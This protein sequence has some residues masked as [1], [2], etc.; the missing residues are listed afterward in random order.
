MRWIASEQTG[1]WVLRLTEDET[2]TSCGLFAGS[3]HGQGE[4]L[5]TDAERKLVGGALWTCAFTMHRFGISVYRKEVLEQEVEKI[6]GVLD[7]LSSFEY[8]EMGSLFQIVSTER[9]WPYLCIHP[10]LSTSSR[11]GT[12]WDEQTVRNTLLLHA[13]FERELLTLATPTF[14]LQHWPLSHFLTYRKIRKMRREKREKWRA[15]GKGKK[16]EGRWQRVVK[17]WLEEMEWEDEVEQE[18]ESIFGTER[19]CWEDGFGQVER[20]VV[21][22]IGAF[23]GGLL[24]GVL[25]R[26]GE[27]AGDEESSRQDANT[28]QYASPTPTPPLPS[29]HSSPSSP[30]DLSPPYCPFP[31]VSAL[32]FPIPRLGTTLAPAPL[33]A[34][35]DLLTKLFLF[36]HQYTEDVVR[37]HIL[38]VREMSGEEDERAVDTLSRVARLIGVEEEH[39]EELEKCVTVGCRNDEATRKAGPFA[40][41]LR[42]VWG[43]YDEEV[44]YRGTFLERYER[45]G[46]FL[47]PRNEKISAMMEGKG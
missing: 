3:R 34:Y 44:R 9:C 31:Q 5:L 26:A 14:L 11:I 39:L 10:N 24:V 28:D 40:C 32:I 15:L 7:K 33:L 17:A 12:A 8:D 20:S 36:A 25:L 42:H 18:R 13:G 29:T 21:R 4:G 30:S 47:V 41:L 16:E 22:E 1:G 46:G 27:R 2:A 45:A 19:W 37:L 35:I 6:T 38:R 43:F 23:E